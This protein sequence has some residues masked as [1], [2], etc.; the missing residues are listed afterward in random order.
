ML[1]RE[2]LDGAGKRSPGWNCGDL[3]RSVTWRAFIQFPWTVWRPTESAAML[4]IRIP[5]EVRPTL[6]PRPREKAE[7]DERGHGPRVPRPV[8][9]IAARSGHRSRDSD[10]QHR[11]A[12]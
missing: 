2:P 9:A 8:L 4:G 5:T 12:V 10:P 11:R 7:G 1:L 3:A 6:M